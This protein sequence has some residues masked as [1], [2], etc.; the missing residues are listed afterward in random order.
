MELDR[1][2]VVILLSKDIWN[3]RHSITLSLDA[4]TSEKIVVYRPKE[5]TWSIES[6]GAAV[7]AVE[8]SSTITPPPPVND[9]RTRFE[10]SPGKLMLD[11]PVSRK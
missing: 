8:I 9:L 6:L 11:L 5:A 7:G 3:K 2:D 1:D 4:F 10:S